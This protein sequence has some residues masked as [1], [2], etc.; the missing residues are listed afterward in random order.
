MIEGKIVK[1]NRHTNCIQKKVIHSILCITLITSCGTPNA[2]YTGEIPSTESKALRL[3]FKRFDE[4]LYHQS[5]AEPAS[6]A[7]SL[8]N[9][10]Q[11]FFCDFVETDIRIGKCNDSLTA[12]ELKKFRNHPD[13]FST[14]EEIEKVFTREKMTELENAIMDIMI[15]KSHFFPESKV[16][17][18]IFYQAAWN[19]RIFVSDSTVGIALD[20]Y[21]GK[22]SKAISS[23]SPDVFP[24]YKK[25]DMIP[26][27]ILPDLAKSLASFE[28]NR[29]YNE[30]GTLLDE[31]II[32]GKMLCLSKALA[33][34]IE[35][36]TILSYTEQQFL[37]ASENEWNTWKVLA[38]NRTL[39]NTQRR[40][41]DRWFNE[42]P[43]TGAPGIPQDSAP[44]LGAYIGWKM[45]RQYAEKHPDLS[46]K[47][48]LS[49]S[50]S[51]KF[52]E[53]YT[54]QKK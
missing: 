40:D 21:L 4:D 13:I 2:P 45:V 47:N 35:D 52:L 27:M 49:I 44:Q 14:H 43:F 42:G 33:P 38:D 25:Q 16:Q 51:R 39:Y 46:L 54:P 37:W 19:N 48:L 7:D 26:E 28:C 29:Y 23:L 12:A 10:Y 53:T 31:I 6:S 41:I 30:K 3:T 36:S 17:E 22:D 32:F 15:R 5:F 9:S 11:N 24:Q 20:H 1:M 8:R 50:D 34:E 18:F